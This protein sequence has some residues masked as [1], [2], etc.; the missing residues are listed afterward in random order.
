VSSSHSTF[1]PQVTTSDPAPALAPK[2]PEPLD[3]SSPLVPAT[4]S[5][6]EGVK[7]LPRRKP[8]QVAERNVLEYI[9]G[10]DALTEL[11]KATVTAGQRRRVKAPI[12]GTIPLICRGLECKFLGY[13]DLHK[14]NIPLPFEKPCPLEQ[15]LADQWRDDFLASIDYDDTGEHSAT[16]R[17]I[18]DE[19]VG[20]L[21]LQSRVAQDTARDAAIERTMNI[22]FSF[23]GQPIEATKL[24][25]GFDLLLRI[26]HAR[27]KLLAQL[28]ATPRAKADSGRLES[29][30][31]GTKTAATHAAAAKIR[32]EQGIAQHG[33]G[34]KLEIPIFLPEGS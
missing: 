4:P 8:S 19:L 26:A 6:L 3:T 24:Y 2:A 31:P 15:N 29:N 25:P 12:G 1:G 21:I 33:T 30:D 18:V 13:C 17:S 34:K 22:G 32:Q 11:Q 7:Q 14:A 28:L 23:Q 9:A 10:A 5:S 20:M 16:I 27:M